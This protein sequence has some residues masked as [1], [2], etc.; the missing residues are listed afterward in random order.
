MTTSKLY[1]VW[2][3][4]GGFGHYINAVLSLHGHG[5]ARPQQQLTFSKNGNSH[6]LDVVAPAYF[7]D[8][9]DYQ[10]DFDPELNY[11]V[12]VDNGITNEGTRF[13]QYFPDATVIKMCYSD[14]SWPVV[15]HT[16]IIKAMRSS[17]ESELCIDS[18]GWDS[19]APWVQREKYFLF[20]RD[21]SF[22]HMWKPDSISTPIMIEDLLD[23]QTLIKKIN[24]EVD[25]FEAS[26][27]QWKKS[28]EQYFLP[29]MIAQRIL[30]GQF[31]LV[32]DVWTQAVVYY[33][34]WCRYGVEV[35]HNDYSN[36]FT[37]YDDIVIMLD[38]HGVD[39]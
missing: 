12:L 18:S 36:W 20:L 39:H 7:K 31:E 35:P 6:A 4:S 19:V 15:A 16:M 14:F 9:N 34:I 30:N 29:T 8:P 1:C 28:N 32:S 10:F 17:I 27:H 2:Y 5:F 38:K 21:H 11:S 3:P 22:R 37:S 26:W 13:R 24:V 25:D 33:Q 23:Y